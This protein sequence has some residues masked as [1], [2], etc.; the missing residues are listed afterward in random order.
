MRH[1]NILGHYHFAAKPGNKYK[2]VRTLKGIFKI[3]LREG[4][5]GRKNRNNVKQL[6]MNKIQDKTGTT[7]KSETG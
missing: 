1:V 6:K 3:P 4:G 5:K 2:P 7:G